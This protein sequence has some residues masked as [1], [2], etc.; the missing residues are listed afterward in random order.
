MNS[1]S[2]QFFRA[3]TLAMSLV[4]AWPAYAEESAQ[5][6][7]PAAPAAPAAEAPAVEAEKSP[8]LR[9]LDASS[10]ESDTRESTPER[11]VRAA[12][13]GGS[14]ERIGLARDVHLAAGERADALVA[15]LGS[16]TSE[17][18]VGDAVIAV[19]GNARVTGRV[20]DSVIAVLGGVY[21]DS[22]VRGDVV[23]VMG[24]VELG[25]RARVGGDVVSVGGA[26]K[27]DP[28]AVVRG[29][30]QDISFGRSGELVTAPWLQSWLHRCARLL[31]LL[32]FSAEVS[33]AWAVALA[34]LTLYVV[35]ALLFR[36]GVERG[37]RTFETRPGSSILASLLIA[38]LTPVL[39]LLLIVSLIG[40]VLVPFIG[41]F[42]MI[43]S[44]FGHA[45][46]LAW[47][48]RRLTQFFGDGPLNHPAVAVLVG[49][50]LVLVLYA[51]PVVGI[52]TYKLIG[53]L[54]LGVALYT[55]MLASRREKPVPVPAVAAPSGVTAPLVPMAVVAGAGPAPE[56]VPPLPRVEPVVASAALPR[57]DFG[58]RFAALL[59]DFIL[60]LVLTE[61]VSDALHSSLTVFS[62]VLNP[63]HVSPIDVSGPSV[64]LVL[65]VYGAL[66]WKLKGTTIGGIVCRLKVVRVDGREIDWSTAIV[67]ALGCFVS[68]FVVG[69]GFL[70]IAVDDQRQAWHDK[71]AGTLVVRVPGSGPM[72]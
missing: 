65:A 36:S 45:I 15:V 24:G 32:A 20:G 60:V 25:P 41:T 9:R 14:G 13:R 2:M 57:A 33:W 50:V 30:V 19:L 23:S 52:L 70:W 29:D 35:I 43:A 8:P 59:I 12:Q 16:A 71:I 34:F 3:G 39:I 47:L 31:R 48:G 72:V 10:V 6:P 7:E 42:L 21:I 4:L 18:E 63:G 49:G 26:I 38:L 62:Q 56:A 22:E 5:P 61:V 1:H 69:L 64:L 67:R 68:L 27:R 37:V 53:L 66:M 28:A 46:L 17:G 55:L 11:V 54:G 51:T 44:L 58:L 40:I